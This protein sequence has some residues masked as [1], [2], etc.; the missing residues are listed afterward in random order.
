M[1][2]YARL[3]VTKKTLDLVRVQCKEEFVKNNP[4]FEQFEI[5]DDLIVHRI[6]I[7]YLTK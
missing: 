5:T 4:M 7:Y 2:Q 3:S 6:A 1:K